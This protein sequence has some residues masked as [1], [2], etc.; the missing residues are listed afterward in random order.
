MIVSGDLGILFNPDMVF[1]EET[2]KGKYKIVAENEVYTVTLYE[3]LKKSEISRIMGRITFQIEC[4]EIK[5]EE[6]NEK[7][8]AA[9]KQQD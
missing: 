3:N 6:A 4:Q 5:E 9:T 1:C 2:S 8:P 7:S